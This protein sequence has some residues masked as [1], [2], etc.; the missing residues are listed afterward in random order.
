[1]TDVATAPTDQTHGPV[2]LDEQRIEEFAGELFGFYTGGM[3]TYLIDIGRRTG[4]FEAAAEG[5]ATSAG[6]ADRAGLHE[7]YV[8]EWLGAMVTGGVIDYDADAG[9]YRLPAEH[10][11]CLTGGGANDLAPFARLNTHLAKHVADITEAFREGGGV[12]YQEY[13]PEFTD[14]MDG[15]GRGGLDEALLSDWLPL[16]PDVVERLTAGARVVDVGCGTGHAI[17]LM[18]EAF[19]RSEF[20]GIDIAADA[21]EQARAEAVAAGVDNV[22]FEVEDAADLT[23]DEPFDVAFVFDAIHD[24]VEPATVL[25]NIRRAL[26]SDGVF[27]MFEPAI[28]SNL[29]DNVAHPLA[30][31]LY[32]ISTLHCLTI[33]LAHDGAA[34]GTAWG[35]QVACD[36][37]RDAGFPD[38][39]VEELPNEP[40]NA[41][42]V[43]RRS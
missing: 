22:R 42:F 15:L 2:A 11:A 37:L 14:V 13:R 4:L 26:T 8:R 32:A 24:Q 35:Q 3:L 16:V 34:L 31:F 23:A 40:I 29:E 27:L 20:V 21:I 18:A 5:P 1:M 6:L 39:T 10:A 30:P 28:S 19:P 38:V 12:P 25:A 33:S 9:V 36:M 17:V 43:A 7:R 41:L